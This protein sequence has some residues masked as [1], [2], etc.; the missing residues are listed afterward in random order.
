M[1]RYFPNR[2][3]NREILSRVSKDEALVRAAR[4]EVMRTL[5]EIR[6]VVPVRA[7][8][9]IFQKATEPSS[10]DRGQEVLN[11][12]QPQLEEREFDIL[13][14]RL[15]VYGKAESL[16]EIGARHGIT[17]QRVFSILEAIEKRVGDALWGEVQRCF[18]RLSG[19]PMSD[20]TR[21]RKIRGALA[22][23]K[24]DAEFLY[25]RVHERA[26][27]PI[28]EHRKLTAHLMDVESSRLALYEDYSVK[29]V[30][31]LYRMCNRCKKALPIEAFY[32]IG[33]SKQKPTAR[34]RECSKEICLDWQRRQ[35]LA[36]SGDSA[37]N[38]SEGQ[39]VPS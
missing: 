8:S 16:G 21:R 13:V 2:E 28:P 19:R 39:G 11:R 14:R 4:Q 36:R 18:G 27:V 29:Q 1:W 35:K 6:S 9:K 37:G 12:L 7:Y 30:G 23:A 26:G 20:V 31:D 32:M 3:P 15:G 17:R 34:C 24:R 10:Q 38:R 22:N 5:Q 33:E 25:M